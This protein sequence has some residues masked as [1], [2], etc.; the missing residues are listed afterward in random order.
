[1]RHHAAGGVPARTPRRRRAGLTL[2]EVLVALTVL[3]VGALAVAGGIAAAAR[4]L[5]RSAEA[6]T[7]TRIAVSRAEWLRAG[8]CAAAERTG[9]ADSAGVRERWSARRSGSLAT[10]AA[11][12]W[13]T[14]VRGPRD[15]ASARHT[16][17]C[18]P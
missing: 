8:A 4:A 5:R 17:W 15:S 2:V 18:A 9:T 10:L 1:M 11:D 3:V 13:R 16:V 12:A 6:A 7:L 14:P